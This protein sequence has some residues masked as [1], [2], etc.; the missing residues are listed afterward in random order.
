[1][2]GAV[3][4]RCG[5]ETETREEGVRREIG[6]EGGRVDERRAEGKRVQF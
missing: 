4:E 1:M 2:P 6:E 3:G 5:A